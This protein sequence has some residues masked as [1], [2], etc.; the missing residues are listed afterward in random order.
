MLASPR[1]GADAVV[2]SMQPRS[3]IGRFW[4][5]LVPL[6]QS[7]TA[8]V[9]AR[10]AS[11]VA[12]V[13]TS[14]GPWHT[15]SL[16]DHPLVGRIFYTR[17]G[18][19]VPRDALEQTVRQTSFVLLG[20][21]HDNADHHRLQSELLHTIV[22]GGRKPALVVEMIDL[23]QQSTLDAA[24]TQTPDD[25]RA[26]ADAVRWEKRGWP[27]FEIYAPIFAV[28]HDATLPIY[29]GDFPAASIKLLFHG[30]SA[31]DDATRDDL[32]VAAPLAPVLDASLRKELVA[33]HCGMLEG[34]EAE[35]LPPMSLAQRLRDGEMAKT[36]AT[37]AHEDGAVLVAGFGHARL[38]RGVPLVLREKWK[39]DP[40]AVVSVAFVEVERGVI[41]PRA[42]SAAF[43]TDVLPFDYV[44][45]TPRVD[46]EDPC[47]AMRTRSK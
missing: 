22:A 41:D 42:Y 17:T 20:E 26:W 19:I 21:K 37:R 23:D 47:A 25:V 12:A 2:R 7:L 45:F 6:L 3:V 39:V 8:C 5:L 14:G 18:E 43:F 27:A 13:P 44:W 40:S 33:S 15:A 10:H 31:I 16:V 32:G 24:R 34:H 30:A 11:D 36:I 4:V 28:A 9:P 1:A 29:G 35:A 46:E 38:D